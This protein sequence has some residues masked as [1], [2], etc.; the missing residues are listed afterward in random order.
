M[1]SIEKIAEKIA[2]FGDDILKVIIPGGMTF[3]ASE[4]INKIKK[5]DLDKHATGGLLGF[6]ESSLGVSIISDILYSSAAYNHFINNSEINPDFIQV[7][8]ASK[9]LAY[10]FNKIAEYHT[11]SASD[12]HDLRKIPR[13]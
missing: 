8:I 10:G 4:N 2:E 13:S 5:Y 11:K 6:S 3:K 9:A 12:E 7:V 1:K